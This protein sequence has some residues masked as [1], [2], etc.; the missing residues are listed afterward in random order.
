MI[1]V[2]IYKLKLLY[3][4]TLIKTEYFLVFVTIDSLVANYA[5]G[6]YTEW[7]KLK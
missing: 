3:V 4:E 5:Y 6:N 2:M 7:G 1:W